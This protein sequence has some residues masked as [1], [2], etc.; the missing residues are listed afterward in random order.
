M[1]S[2]LLIFSI[3][4]T[5]SSPFW[6]NPGRSDK[7]CA[8]MRDGVMVLMKDGMVVTSDVTLKDSTK[9]TTNCIVIRKDGSKINLKDGEC[10]TGDGTGKSEKKQK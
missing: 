4:L 7:Y 10:I 9:V 5:L 2:L 8:A 6:G 3:C 1:K